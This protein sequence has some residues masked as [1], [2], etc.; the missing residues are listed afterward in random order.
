MHG[1]PK[2]MLDSVFT[3]EDSV[4]NFAAIWIRTLSGIGRLH[5]G[6]CRSLLK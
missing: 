2:A 1:F 5:Q 3:S 4:C 6:S